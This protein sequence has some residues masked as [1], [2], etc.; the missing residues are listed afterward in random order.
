MLDPQFLATISLTSVYVLADDLTQVDHYIG[1]IVILLTDSLY[2]EAIE[3]AS[4]CFISLFP[5]VNLDSR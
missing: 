3:A 2:T 1:L 5:G 4:G